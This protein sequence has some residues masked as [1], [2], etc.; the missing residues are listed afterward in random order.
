MVRRGRWRKAW[1]IYIIQYHKLEELRK[2]MIGVLLSELSSSSGLS[3]GF[4]SSFKFELPCCPFEAF[5]AEKLFLK[6]VLSP[7]IKK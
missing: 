1:K 7:E 2:I 6:E 3:W 4:S 5:A